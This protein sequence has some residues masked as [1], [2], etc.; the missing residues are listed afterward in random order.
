LKKYVAR[1]GLALPMLSVLS[2]Q[3]LAQSG[4]TILTP[5][6]VVTGQCYGRG[7]QPGCVLPN[8]YGPTGLTLFSNPVSSHF[9][10]FVGSAQT[11]LNQTLSTAIATKLAILPIISPASGF[12]Y[13]YDSAAGAFV[14]TSSS[15][16]P[17]S[18]PPAANELR[19]VQ[20]V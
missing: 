9:A 6:T 18:K 11:T 14:R 5:G 3:C 12:T 17:C 19:R 15:F 10:H 1:F 20:A 4:S 8:L 2:F 13:M 16:G 7:S